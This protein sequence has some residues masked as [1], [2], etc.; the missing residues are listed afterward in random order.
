MKLRLSGQ[1][2][3]SRKVRLRRLAV[4]VADP[5][6]ARRTGRGPSGTLWQRR[7][8]SVALRLPKRRVRRDRSGAPMRRRG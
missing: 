6:R 5:A 8:Q 1:L 2:V 7:M 4:A 3:E